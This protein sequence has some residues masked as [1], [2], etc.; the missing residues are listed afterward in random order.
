MFD[1]DPEDFRGGSDGE[2]P[3]GS[4]PEIGTVEGIQLVIWTLFTACM[5]IAVGVVVGNIIVGWYW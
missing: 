2:F 4:G 5:V 3:I 1:G